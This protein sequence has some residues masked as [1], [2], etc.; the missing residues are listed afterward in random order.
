MCAHSGRVHV[1]CTG[2]PF[3]LAPYKWTATVAKYGLSPHRMGDWGLLPLP[4]ALSD[5]GA[6]VVAGGPY[7]LPILV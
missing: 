2:R 1:C 7:T 6:G 5:V 3:V 4:D